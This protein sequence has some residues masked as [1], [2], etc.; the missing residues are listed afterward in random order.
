MN[1][2]LIERARRDLALGL[3]T[4]RDFRRRV[5]MAS[6]RQHGLEE[7][8][9]TLVMQSAFD[10]WREQRPWRWAGR[11]LQS[12]LFGLFGRREVRK[13]MTRWRDGA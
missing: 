3:A 6:L 13:M 5:R 2:A 9:I 11:R 4:R 12:W 8:D 10:L 7:A 1:L